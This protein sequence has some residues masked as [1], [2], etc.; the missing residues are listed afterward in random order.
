MEKGFTDAEAQLFFM[1]F[2]P[3][4][5]KQKMVF[6]VMRYTGR[7]IGEVVQLKITDINFDQRYIKF[8]RSKLVGGR[9]KYDFV[10]MVDQLFFPLLDYVQ[11]HLKEILQSGG[12]IF[13]SGSRKGKHLSKD[14]MRNF[15]RKICKRVGLDHVYA[16]RRG[17]GGKL[18]RLTTHSFR[19]AFISKALFEKQ[20]PIAL[21]ARMVGHTNIKSTAAYAHAPKELVDK[22]MIELWA[23]N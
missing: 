12:W 23:E 15:F 17:D 4:E 2:Y 22:A 16:I 1:G 20:M 19:H 6:L 21:V 3:E 8:K 7:R 14:Y 11:G 10:F 18:H 5:I 13:Y 9:E